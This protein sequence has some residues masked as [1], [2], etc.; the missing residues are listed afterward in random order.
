MEYTNNTGWGGA[1]ALANSGI[2]FVLYIILFILFNLDVSP[3]KKVR[4]TIQVISQPA[5]FSRNEKS[6]Q[7]TINAERTL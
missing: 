3:Y 4:M 2:F 6:L 7:N 5:S 1:Y